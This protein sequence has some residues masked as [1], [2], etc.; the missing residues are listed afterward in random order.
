MLLIA[1]GAVDFGRV[2]FDYIGLRN[3]A[4]EG[5]IYG[6]RYLNA[7]PDEIEQRVRDHF[8]PNPAPSDLAITP[9]VDSNCTII[10]EPPGFV[11]VTVTRPFSPLSLAALQFV[12]P[13]TNWDVTVT[14]T[15]RARCM[16]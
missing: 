14:A 11:T 16:T 6:S 5:A 10:G 9:A 3:A 13:D 4:I 1:L 8:L 15:A 12:A 7:S 2:F